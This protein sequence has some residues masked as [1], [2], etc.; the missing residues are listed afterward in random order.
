MVLDLCWECGG[1]FDIILLILWRVID[2]GFFGEIK[3]MFSLKC[4]RKISCDIGVNILDELL[5]NVKRL[6]NIRKLKT[7]TR[8]RVSFIST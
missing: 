7:Q 8:V 5:V 3:N 2:G 1:S 4:M 6:C